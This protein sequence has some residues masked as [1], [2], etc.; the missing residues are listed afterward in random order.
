MK[1]LFSFDGMYNEGNW[2]FVLLEG[3]GLGEDY[4][5]SLQSCRLVGWARA[6]VL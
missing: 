6:K 4:P 2:L 1:Y 3:P 5:V